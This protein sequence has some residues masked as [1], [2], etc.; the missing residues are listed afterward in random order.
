MVPAD[1]A[2]RDDV[3]LLA[4][5]YAAAVRDGDSE[6]TTARLYRF[7]TVPRTPA[8]AG[9][10]GDPVAARQLLLAAAGLDRRG[11]SG[12]FTLTTPQA[13]NGWLYWRSSN[14]PRS[15]A[16]RTNDADRTPAMRKLYVTA[17]LDHLPLAL[18]AVFQAA[19]GAD[20]SVVKFGADYVNLR[21]PDR[22]VLYTRGREHA[23][24]VEAGLRAALD[25]VPADTLPFAERIS[26][27]VFTGLDPPA[28]AGPAS[29]ERPAAPHA[30]PPAASPAGRRV[31]AQSAVPAGTSWRGWVCRNV[32]QALHLAPQDNAEL[33]VAGA[34]QRC[35]QLGLDP[36]TWAVGD[37]FFAELSGA[38]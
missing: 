31:P 32:A 4:L 6:R 15:G 13:N 11:A 14:G 3:S 36:S 26:A 7:N 5:R 8:H 19:H 21:R 34:I 17:K 25:G 20:V 10:L 2:A 18:R 27:A 23:D 9:L 12:G 28:S 29:A 1:Q 24:Q 33:A 16:W 35:R 37:G 30:A 38:A 22:I